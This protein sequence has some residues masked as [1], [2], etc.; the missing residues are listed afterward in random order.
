MVKYVGWRP[1]P[2]EKVEKLEQLRVLERGFRIKV[3]ETAF[4]SICVDTPEDLEMARL[5]WEKSHVFASGRG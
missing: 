3:A 1:T 4:D 5:Y 2:L